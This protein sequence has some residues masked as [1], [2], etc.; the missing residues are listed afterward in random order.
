MFAGP[1]GPRSRFGLHSV[2]FGNLVHRNP[3]SPSQSKRQEQTGTET[4]RYFWQTLSP[5]CVWFSVRSYKYNGPKKWAGGKKIISIRKMKPHK[6][7][8]GLWGNA[9]APF[10]D[11]DPGQL[12][13]HSPPPRTSVNLFMIYSQNFF[14]C[15]L[16]FQWRRGSSTRAMFCYFITMYMD[17]IM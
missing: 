8:N 9:L 13:E 2:T 10:R 16:Y 7:L 3:F 5:T 14:P 4:W 11:R 15:L 1:P 12:W 17:F 6:R